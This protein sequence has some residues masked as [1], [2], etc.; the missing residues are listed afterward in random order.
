MTGSRIRRSQLALALL[1]AAWG[2]TS[3]FSAPSGGGSDGLPEMDGAPAPD[4]EPLPTACLDA[5]A[6]A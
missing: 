1:L 2:C 5:L 6:A 4:G 3:D